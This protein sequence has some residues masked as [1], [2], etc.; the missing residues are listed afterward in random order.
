VHLAAPADGSVQTGSAVDV[1]IG[2]DAPDAPFALELNGIDVTARV[3]GSGTTRTLVLAGVPGRHNALRYGANR[4][5]VRDAT[6]AQRVDFAWRPRRARVRVI[7]VGNELEFAAYTSPATWQAEVDRIFAEL[8]A[9]RLAPGRPNVVVLTEDFGLPTALLGT[10]GAGARAQKDADAL[11]ALTNLFVTYFPQ[12]NHYA[13]TATLPGTG[14]QPLARAL[15]LALTDGLWRN[16]APLM[17]QKAQQYGVWLAA[18]TNVAEVA[19]STDPEAVAFFGDADDPGRTDVWLPQ[20][21]D[22]WN[23]AFLWGPD[24]A[25]VGRT[26][27]VF[28]TPPEVEVLNLSTGSLD[29]VQ[30]FDTPAGRIAFAISKDAFIDA[31]VRRMDDLGAT[32]VLQPDANPGLWANRPTSVW[33]PD[34]WTGSVLGMLHERYPSV[35]V[36]ATSMMVGNFF[37]GVIDASGEPTGILFD[38]QSSITRRGP[39]PVRRGFV[40]MSPDLGHTGRFLDLAPWAF[41]DP[42]TVRGTAGLAAL[43]ARCGSAVGAG[44]A[45]G[46]LTLEQRRGILRDCARS[47]LPGQPNADGYRENV[48][49]ADVTLPVAP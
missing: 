23:T 37:P 30:V 6:S 39:R 10:R 31:Y 9:P 35:T 11:T 1:A 27:K 16:F 4:L 49:V 33:Q 18:C 34:D 5:V 8:V 17:A 28:L 43:R 40:A 20:G 48:A 3:R 15:T 24:G 21:T 42:A 32:L 19:R 14:L 7:A 44:L 2:L 13:T 38:G 47:L 12:A 22:V 45:P 41:P 36:N 46:Q 26:R 25:L 29:D